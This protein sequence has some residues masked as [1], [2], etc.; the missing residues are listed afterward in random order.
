MRLK[1]DITVKNVADLFRSKATE[2]E[3][4]VT[5]SLNAFYYWMNLFDVRIINDC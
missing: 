5:T 4:F 2:N 1:I 3:I